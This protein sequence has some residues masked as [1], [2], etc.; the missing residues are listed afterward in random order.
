MR[1]YVLAPEAEQD[2]EAILSWTDQQ[3]GPEARL[4]YEALV[5]QAITNVTTAP[6]RPGAHDR[7]D[8]APAARVYHLRHSRTRVARTVGRV[9]SPRHILLFRPFSG[10]PVEIARILH[11]SMDLE[12]WLPDDFRLAD[13]EE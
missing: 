10:G 8:L 11:D 5:I 3:Y 7:S 9:K 1:Q 2:L 12:T 6:E 4:R 13:D